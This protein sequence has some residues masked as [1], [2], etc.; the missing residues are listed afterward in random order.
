MG[1]IR[2]QSTSTSRRRC[3]ARFV[4]A[5]S[6]AG[7]QRRIM[8]PERRLPRP[9][10]APRIAPTVLVG[11][12][13]TMGK[14][15][16]SGRGSCRRSVISRSLLTIRSHWNRNTCVCDPLGLTCSRVKCWSRLSFGPRSGSSAT[17]GSLQRSSEF[18]PSQI[19]WEARVRLVSRNLGTRRSL[20]NWF[21]IILDHGCSRCIQITRRLRSLSIGRRLCILLKLQL[22]CTT[23]ASPPW[24]GQNTLDLKPPENL[25]ARAEVDL[26]KA[27]RMA[28]T[29]D[30]F[31]RRVLAACE[32]YPGAEK[33]IP[34]MAAR[35]KAVIASGGAM[36]KHWE[37]L[38][39]CIA[40]NALRTVS[41]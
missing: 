9:I 37:V 2:A 5:P 35:I 39:F 6:F 16:G 19:P 20:C 1:L 40:A 4:V 30:T 17:S 28:D 3:V 29:F 14:R 13:N 26:R 7:L 27:E 18:W 38:M 11:R 25:W 12:L 8:S 21:G 33:L 31:K 32:S 41:L 36:T 22:L 34:S 24:S 15:Q 10:P 23:S